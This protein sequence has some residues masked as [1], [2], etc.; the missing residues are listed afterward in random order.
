MFW[1][2]LL[3]LT[4]LNAFAC[5][6][7]EIQMNRR[8]SFLLFSLQIRTFISFFLT[9]YAVF[10]SILLAFVYEVNRRE[11]KEVLFNY[12]MKFYDSYLCGLHD[13]P[14]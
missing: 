7:N 3:I 2:Y 14:A 5:Q 8:T 12:A 6:L 11:K 1:S 4:K 10:F 9:S 13:I